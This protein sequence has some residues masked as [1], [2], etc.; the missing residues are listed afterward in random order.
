MGGDV[1]GSDG[2]LVELALVLVEGDDAS[3]AASFLSSS[4]SE[5]SPNWWEAPALEL[6]VGCGDCAT[7]IG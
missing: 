2:V 4:S 3:S 6:F 7:V 5:S 1:V